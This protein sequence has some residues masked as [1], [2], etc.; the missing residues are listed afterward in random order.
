MSD[1]RSLDVRCASS[2]AWVRHTYG[3]DEVDWI[4]VVDATTS[5]CYYVRSRTWA[6]MAR[7]KLR[8]APAANGQRVRIRPAEAF[9]Y[10]ELDGAPPAELTERLAMLVD[11]SPE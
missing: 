10:P 4:A 7:P 8:L 6:G 2:S 1:G 9:L 11:P 5:R 3:A